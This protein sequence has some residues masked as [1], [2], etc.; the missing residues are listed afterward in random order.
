LNPHKSIKP[1]A[2]FTKITYSI[3]SECFVTVKVYDILGNEVETIVSEETPAGTYQKTWNASG[4][5][6]GIYFYSIKA[7]NFINTKKM[8]MIK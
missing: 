2:R 8:L 1:S 5:T 4:L 3:P 6:S 7:G